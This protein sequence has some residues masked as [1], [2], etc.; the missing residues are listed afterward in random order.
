MITQIVKRKGKNE[1]TI[2]SD[3]NTNISNM[4]KYTNKDKSRKILT[5]AE[6]D[7]P[8]SKGVISTVKFEYGIK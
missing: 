5:L 6:S 3:I 8:S 2:K 1:Y 4:W 7:K